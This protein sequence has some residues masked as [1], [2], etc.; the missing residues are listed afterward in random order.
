MT[1]NGY[2]VHLSTDLRVF[3]ITFSILCSNLVA[4]FLL[5]TG[6]IPKKQW[7]TVIHRSIGEYLNLSNC[8]CLWTIWRVSLSLLTFTNYILLLNFYCSILIVLSFVYTRTGVAP[9]VVKLL[10][11]KEKKIQRCLLHTCTFAKLKILVTHF[12]RNVENLRGQ[13]KVDSSQNLHN[14]VNVKLG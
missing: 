7:C 6:D 3:V 12:C 5:S 14:H 10:M 9:K 1:W 13:I 11:T 8:F 2:R 4:Y